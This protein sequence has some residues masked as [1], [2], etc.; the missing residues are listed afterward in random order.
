[1]P[2]IKLFHSG[3]LVKFSIYFANLRVG[4]FC[5]IVYT[6]LCYIRKI[7]KFAFTHIIADALILITTIVICAYNIFKIENRGWGNNVTFIN[8]EYWLNMIGFS[9]YSYEGI[10]IILPILDITKKPE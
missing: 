8:S 1:M 9:V 7:E 3:F 2:L 10:G 6:P 5:F 4:I